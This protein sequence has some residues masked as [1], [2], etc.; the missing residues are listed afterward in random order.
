MDIKQNYREESNLDVYAEHSLNCAN[1]T[2]E[3]VKWLEAKLTLT[4]VSQQRE[5][6]D[7]FVCTM[8]FDIKHE[9]YQEDIDYF[10]KNVTTR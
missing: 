1:Y 2:N 8:E 6:L 5:M 7:A 4:D 3:Y 10:L 9:T